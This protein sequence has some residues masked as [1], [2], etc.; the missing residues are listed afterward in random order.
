[1][2]PHVETKLEQAKPNPT[3]TCSSKYNLRHKAKPKSN[4][5]YRY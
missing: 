5:D 3:N 4:D 1:M 2:E